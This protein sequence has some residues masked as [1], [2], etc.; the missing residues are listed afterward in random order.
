M[1]LREEWDCVDCIKLALERLQ[2]GTG[3][4]RLL[5]VSENQMYNVDGNFKHKKN[6]NCSC[7]LEPP[8]IANTEY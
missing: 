7:T 4:N 6:I 5:V 3:V 8:V 2:W 1:E